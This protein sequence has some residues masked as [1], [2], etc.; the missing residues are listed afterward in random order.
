MLEVVTMKSQALFLLIDVGYAGAKKEGL[1][2]KQ[3]NA[4]PQR[5]P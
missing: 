3:G 2:W 5:L 4:R 1:K